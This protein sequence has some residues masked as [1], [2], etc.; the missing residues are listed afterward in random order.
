SLQ[1]SWMEWPQNLDGTKSVSQRFLPHTPI[2][3]VK[4]DS[5][6]SVAPAVTPSCR[7]LCTVCGDTALGKHY[8]VNACNGCKGF[9]RRT[10]WK[11]RTYKCRGDNQCTIDIEQRNSCRACRYDKCVRMGMNSRAVQG[12]LKECRKNGVICTAP[13]NEREEEEEEELQ[14]HSEPED[15]Y[16]EPLRQ[17]EVATVSTQTKEEPRVFILSQ[18]ITD[19]VSRF[20]RVC[21]RCEPP[22]VHPI[23]SA[24][25]VDFATIF[26]HP[27]LVSSRTPIDPS[28]TR[29]ATL[30]DI[31]GDYRRAFVLFCDLMHATPEI[32]EMEEADRVLMG[33]VS[34]TSFY[35][36]MTAFWGIDNNV[37]GVCY[38]NGSYFPTDKEHQQFP[39][40]K[41]CSIRAVFNLNDPVRSLLLTDSEQAVVAYLACFIEGVP[42]LST[43]GCKKY[44]AMRDKLIRYLYE[45]AA[46][47]L[48]LRGTCGEL[49]IASRVAQIISLYPSITD[50]CMR[51]SDN[52]EVSEVLQLIKYD[53]WMTK[54]ERTI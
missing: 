48:S 6:S 20:R 43:D 31:L 19:L 25:N 21:D 24:I 30:D 40:D 16:T 41:D 29:I 42:K 35:W 12:D 18:E 4:P 50:L 22:I 3:T 44:S 45:V 17:V 54:K 39:D 34:F 5:C 10:V 33:K 53:P 9:F 2:S 13:K 27:E 11:K 46:N 38:A 49:S 23:T 32:M 1:W 47:C 28:A 14:C 52:M 8:G 26:N 51:A 37:K 15:E 7:V 36:M